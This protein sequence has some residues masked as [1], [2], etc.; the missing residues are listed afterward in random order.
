MGLLYSPYGE[1]CT[2][3]FGQGPVAGFV[4]LHEQSKRSMGKNSLNSALAIS[5][6]LIGSSSFYYYVLFLPQKEAAAREHAKEELAAQTQLQDTQ[7]A[8]L[9][10]CLEQAKTNARIVWSN[11]CKER[12]QKDYCSLS[13]GA[14]EGLSIGFKEMTDECYKR[15]Q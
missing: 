5:A 15:Y 8:L 12:G 7:E 14:G 11:Y 3:G 9:D 6:I 13:V 4:H 1:T 10:G 2:L